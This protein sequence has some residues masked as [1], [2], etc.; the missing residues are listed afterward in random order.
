M[1]C[2]VF[3]SAAKIGF[4]EWR[5]EFR[6]LFLPANPLHYSFERKLGDRK[7]RQIDGGE[8]G[9]R[10]IECSTLYRLAR[11]YSDAGT[12][13]LIGISASA[14]VRVTTERRRTAGTIPPCRDNIN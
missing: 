8:D 9:I 5:P 11:P 2:P 6:N 10:T 1:S 4:S 13:A 3:Q 14:S 12:K 7:E